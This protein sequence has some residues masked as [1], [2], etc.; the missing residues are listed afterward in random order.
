MTKEEKN[1]P[2]KPW[3]SKEER[4]PKSMVKDSRKHLNSRSG[5][6]K[7]FIYN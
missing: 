3:T 6:H 1:K 7:R 2:K 5:K 4:Y